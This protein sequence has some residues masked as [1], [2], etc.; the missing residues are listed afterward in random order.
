MLKSTLQIFDTR[1][2]P[3]DC[4]IAKTIQDALR[5]LEAPPFVILSTLEK[6]SHVLQ[7]PGVMRGLHVII[8]R[9]SDTLKA[10][11]VSIDQ[12]IDDSTHQDGPV[13]GIF[14]CR[15][16]KRKLQK[17]RIGFKPASLNNDIEESCKLL[18]EKCQNY[19]YKIFKFWMMKVEHA[20][21][22]SL[23]T[24]EQNHTLIELHDS[25]TF[26]VTLH[27]ELAI[28]L[29]EERKLKLLGFNTDRIEQ[30]VTIGKKYF[31]MGSF[32]NKAIMMRNHIEQRVS[33][34][35]REFIVN[36]LVEFDDLLN[37]H[38]ETLDPP[39][40][41][42]ESSSIITWTNNIQCEKLAL[43]LNNIANKLSSEIKKVGLHRIDNSR[44]L[45]TFFGYDLLSQKSSWLRHCSDCEE[46]LCEQTTDM[47]SK[48]ATYW[49]HQIM[50]IFDA[51]YARGLGH[52]NKVV[53]DIRC[54]MIMNG[55]KVDI[56]PS[57]SEIRIELY[58]QLRSFIEYPVE[59]KSALKGMIL[60][61]VIPRIHESTIARV[62]NICE[63][64]ISDL[65]GIIAQYAEKVVPYFDMASYVRD[66][67]RRAGDFSVCFQ[68]LKSQMYVVENWPEMET[69]HLGMKLSL[70]KFKMIVADRLL[71]L[72]DSLNDSL[73]KSALCDYQLFQE[74]LT[75]T[76]LLMT[77]TPTDINGIIRVENDWKAA[78]LE[79]LNI[80][81]IS[82][83]GCD[84]FD[85]LIQFYRSNLESSESFR[86]KKKEL[87]L[88]EVS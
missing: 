39:S 78:K 71:F 32:I 27:D 42:H 77:N 29:D 43:K 55:G 41:H 54:E 59:H 25:K 34:E 16:C 65:K 80:E 15:G 31:K 12:A 51:S 72:E 38:C 13:E 23:K 21:D 19:E 8:S 44:R 83:S 63:R 64:Y 52:L 49:G 60:F 5:D 73:Q 82:A 30:K 56:H 88:I 68:W 40:T 76:S 22:L 67:C 84:K 2:K 26:R 70:R 6:V 61:K 20:L 58:A 53:Q 75:A 24:L 66:H 48:W 17:I 79:L 87:M 47:P 10:L 1:L 33:R 46:S 69:I 74:Y 9:L 3:L 45:C 7:R 62:F 4:H 35:E 36:S 11:L 86:A 50:K 18:E 85:L 81:R 14:M 37:K 57:L 28:I